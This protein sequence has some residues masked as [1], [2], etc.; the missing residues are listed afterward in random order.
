[1][2]LFT[3]IAASENH[4]RKHCEALTLAGF[5]GVVSI[6]VLCCAMQIGRFPFN[7]FMWSPIAQVDL[8]LVLLLLLINWC[9]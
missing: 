1:M 8:S 2:L 5:T 6:S 7:I 4:V 3:T 9:V